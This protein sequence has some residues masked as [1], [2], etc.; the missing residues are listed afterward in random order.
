[1]VLQSDL[2][3][4]WRSTQHRSEDVMR[5]GRSHGWCRMHCMGLGLALGL[6]CTFFWFLAA[7]EYMGVY[8]CLC[9]TLAEE[10]VRISR[11]VQGIVRVTL[12]V[13]LRDDSICRA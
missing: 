5:A 1:M 6:H 11:G 12:L 10:D 7:W 3:M 4:W 8:G 9:R 13:S 2:W